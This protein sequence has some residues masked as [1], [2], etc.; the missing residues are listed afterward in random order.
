MYIYIYI[1][2][3]YKYKFCVCVYDLQGVVMSMNRKSKN[4]KVVSSIKLDDPAGL[5]MQES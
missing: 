5:N 2:Y 4:T 3:L 1:I